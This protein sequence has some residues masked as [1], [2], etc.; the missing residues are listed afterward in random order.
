MKMRTRT[1]P[2]NIKNAEISSKRSKY[3]EK[4]YSS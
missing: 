4:I 1:Y 2:F 3:L